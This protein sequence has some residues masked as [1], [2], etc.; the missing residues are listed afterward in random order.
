MRDHLTARLAALRQEEAQA[1][2]QEQQLAAQMEQLAQQRQALQELRWRIAGAIQ[3]L[4]E[5]LTADASAV[6]EGSRA[7]A[8]G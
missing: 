7:E 1:L 2:Q 3:V 6:P 5:C 4:D 8:K